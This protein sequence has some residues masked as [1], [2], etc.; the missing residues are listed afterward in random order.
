[1]KSFAF[2]LSLLLGLCIAQ[3]RTYPNYQSNREFWTVNGYTADPCVNRE[4]LF[5]G[6]NNLGS[7]TARQ[8]CIGNQLPDPSI[9]I[10]IPNLLSN[11]TPLAA[12]TMTLTIIGRNLATGFMRLTTPGGLC[13]S[14]ID[15]TLVAATVSSVGGAFFLNIPAAWQANAL[16]LEVLPRKLCFFA[17]TVDPITTS[18][19]Y[20]GFKIGVVRDCDDTI[21]GKRCVDLV[22]DPTFLNPLSATNLPLSTREQAIRAARTTCI[23][24]TNGDRSG[25]GIQMPMGQCINTNIA[26]ACQGAAMDP[27][28]MKCCD[29]N[30]TIVQ[31]I[32][33]PCFCRPDGATTSPIC[34]SGEPV[35][36]THTKYP[37][38]IRL[39]NTVGLAVFPQ[40]FGECYNTSVH[41]CCDTGYRYDPGQ[42]QC[43][44]I[45]GI[46]SANIPCPCAVDAD[47]QG[48]QS[49]LGQGYTYGQDTTMFCCSQFWPDPYEIGD[50]IVSKLGT[51]ASYTR[52]NK[53]INF[54]NTQFPDTVYPLGTGPYQAQRCFGI[55]IDNRYQTCC[56][57]VAC[58]KQFEYCCN[59]TCCN[60]Y[61]STCT[62]GRIPGTP[63]TRFN[64]NEL[65]QP[66][67][68]CTSIEVLNPLRGFW[69]F[70]WPAYL[71]L[72]TAVCCAF[73]L[74]FITKVS[75]RSFS[76][77]ERAMIAIAFFTIIFACACYFAPIYKYG[78]FLTIVNLFTVIVAGARAK[79]LNIA[80]VVVQLITLL[81]LFDPF[82]GNN[83]L[84]FSSLRVVNGDPDP[85]SGG[86]LYS[87][88]KMMPNL[89][90]FVQQQYCANYYNYFMKDPQLMDFRRDNIA[91]PS[92]GYCSHG[93]ITALY[94]FEGIAL[95]LTLTQFILD[96][97]A[98]ILRYKEERSEEFIR[99]EPEPVE[100][101]TTTTPVPVMPI[102]APSTPYYPFGVA[103]PTTA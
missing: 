5:N 63:N 20:T 41:R 96:L 81:Y 38:L 102:V 47:C 70:V 37:E 84:G 44:N 42:D 99:L 34:P 16:E 2:I 7:T 103:P 83:Y 72:M 71:L 64:Y 31:W 79:P 74:A 18:Y 23:R 1:M 14:N 54:P 60:R 82:S 30:F 73:V 78:V 45:T 52:C 91:V 90:T 56:N 36:C 9:T 65:D 53:Y 28:S 57:G 27:I 13:G 86:I 61:T 33:R 58:R 85:Q 75:R 10:L 26:T 101:T 87:I 66:Y 94:I 49:L 29:S 51:Q 97:I 4:E 92:F 17:G 67:E 15:P 69:V 8:D 77:L 12:Y 24:H 43:C 62:E 68:I 32:N 93:W 35:C 19:A 48:G 76:F 80:L 22:K 39:H 100:Y 89:N 88:Q 55:C 3:P 21:V 40:Y 25:V 59:S 98:L 6:I 50:S 46:Q 95:I 11:P